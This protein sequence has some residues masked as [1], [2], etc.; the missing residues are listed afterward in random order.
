MFVWNLQTLVLKFFIFVLQDLS[1][2]A[3]GNKS[4]KLSAGKSLE[5]PQHPHNAAMMLQGQGMTPQQIQQ[6]IQQQQG[7]MQ[8][9]QQHMLQQ[10]VRE[11]KYYS[12]VT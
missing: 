9:M 5:I 2:K 12:K 10:Q 4:R 8:M 6:L 7:G 3:N 11:S 1:P